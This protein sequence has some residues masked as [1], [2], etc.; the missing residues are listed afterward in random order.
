MVR[1]QPFSSAGRHGSLTYPTGVT[2]IPPD[3]CLFYPYFPKIRHARYSYS[4][5]LTFLP[6]E[7]LRNAQLIPLSLGPTPPPTLDIY[8][9][10]RAVAQQRFLLMS[11]S[12]LIYYYRTVL[13]MPYYIL[14]SKVPLSLRLFPSLLWY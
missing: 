6:P 10:G 2:A 14:R 3:A 4:V 8:D 5:I 13:S 12:S 11:A 9:F 1:K 7:L